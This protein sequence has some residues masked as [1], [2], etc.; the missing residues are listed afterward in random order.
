MPH[1]ELLESIRRKLDALER[2]TDPQTEAE[3]AAI[4]SRLTA[5]VERSRESTALRAGELAAL[6]EFA[7]YIPHTADALPSLVSV[8]DRE[9]RYIYNNSAYSTWFNVAPRHG[10]HVSEVL[11]AENFARARP[12]LERALAGDERTFEI[13]LQSEQG[14]RLAAVTMHPRRAQDGETDGVYVVA[15]DYTARR[16]TQAALTESE[17]RF[18]AFFTDA[19]NRLFV[20]DA[21]LRYEKMNRLAAELSAGLSA[22]QHLGRTPSELDVPLAPAIEALARRVLETGR[23]A[24]RSSLR[25]EDRHF[26]LIA[27]PILGAEDARPVA[28]G[29]A[30]TEITEFKRTEAALRRAEQRFELALRDSPVLVFHQDLELRYTWLNR[31]PTEEPPEA[32]LGKRDDELFSRPEDAAPV[33]ALKREVLATGKGLRRELEVLLPDG[34]RVYDMIYEPLRDDAGELVGITG[35]VVN[36]TAQRNAERRRQAELERRIAE[37]TIE[38]ARERERLQALLD[39]AADAIIGINHVGIVESFSRAAERLFGYRAE[40]VLGRNV[41]MLMVGRDRAQH[42]AYLR[43]YLETG[44]ARVIGRGRNIVGRRKGGREFPLRLSIGE[45]RLSEHRRFVGILHDRTAEAAAERA[46]R[47]QASLVANMSEGVFST[48]LELRIR[49]WNP[50]ASR[51]FGR[52][53]QDVLGQ[54]ACGLLGGESGAE[55]RATLLA[56][57]REHDEWSHELIHRR[58]DGRVVQTTCRASRLPEVGYIFVVADVTRLRE[59]EAE[60]IHAQRMR[61]I[62]TLAS[63]VAHNFN[64]LLMGVGGCATMALETAAIDSPTRAYLEEIRESANSGAAITRQLLD[65]GSKRA[66]EEPVCEL[67]A[68]LRRQRPML[69]RLIG[70]DIEFVLELGA[71]GRAVRFEPTRVEQIVMNLA[72]NARDAM[73][74]ADGRR[75]LIRTEDRPD[76]DQPTIAL[77]VS[78]TGAG[79][80]DAVR[81]RIFEPFFT[82]KRV[83]LGT[84]L[85]LSTVYAMVK[86][87]G[88]EITVTSAPGEG[89]TF[90]VVLPRADTALREPAAEPV[91]APVNPVEPARAAARVVLVVEDERLV[92][93]TI[94]HYLTK[95]GYTVL[96]ASSGPEALELARARVGP[97]ELLLTDIVLPGMSGSALARELSATRPSL[98]ILF[99][100]AHDRSWLISQDRITAEDAAIQ[101]P[102]TE[103]QLRARLD[104]LFAAD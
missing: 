103:A 61:A 96:E 36:I 17:R 59:L 14:P 75:L 91:R 20:L 58:P 85:G 72:I 50:A 51:I 99:M 42:D 97:I 18:T 100:S 47:Y 2:A 28:V 74:S 13:T 43:R 23:P 39:T 37:R 9:F 77:V 94:H 10:A 1:R 80:P 30:L 71:P 34:L 68:L 64:N 101:K 60:N 32:L 93:M 26:N 7:D 78:D 104:E 33:M 88:G 65:F 53:E 86:N 55:L 22:A 73:S 25:R 29:C 92:R 35:V 66:P 62:G 79:I 21:Q 15:S 31:S 54:G 24:K 8:V 52:R 95:A 84:G 5:L 38:L 49:S 56:T 76:G 27:V 4:E 40:E 69:E 19:P 67:D 70:E 82:T 102:F 46:L 41:T 3:L 16:R 90:C 63:G 44:E 6:R 87:A 89:A 57:L 98:K 48:D 81:E 12:Q 11:G 83:G 45:M